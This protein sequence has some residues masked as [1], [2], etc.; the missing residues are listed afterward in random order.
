MKMEN[1]HYG[2]TMSSRDNLDDLPTP[3]EVQIEVNRFLDELGDDG[4][5]SFDREPRRPIPPGGRSSLRRKSSRN[6]EK[7]QR[8][9]R[10]GYF[11]TKPSDASRWDSKRN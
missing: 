3:E 6:S 2:E 7:Y 11:T 5:G 4:D 9:T 1:N 10:S 8:E